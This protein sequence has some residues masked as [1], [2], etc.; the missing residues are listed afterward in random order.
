MN[1]QN[2]SFILKAL[3]GDT[4]DKARHRLTG[5]DRVKQNTFEAGQQLNG[6]HPFIIGGTI[7][8]REV[9]IPQQYFRL[10]LKRKLFCHR[11]LQGDDFRLLIRNASGNRHANQLYVRHQLLK[12]DR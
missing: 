4:V 10:R 2:G 8:R 3:A 11:L 5:I 1:K 9:V 12:P 6:L 7:A